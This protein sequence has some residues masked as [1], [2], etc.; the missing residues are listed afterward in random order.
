MVF[1]P[2]KP[3]SNSH[4]LENGIIENLK[5]LK[6]PLL[7]RSLNAMDES[8]HV[9]LRAWDQIGEIELR[10]FLC[11]TECLATEGLSHSK[12]FSWRCCAV[13]CRGKEMMT[14]AMSRSNTWK[15]AVIQAC[16]GL[17]KV[18]TLICPNLMYQSTIP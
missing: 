16:Y 10:D 6:L 14:I 9:A 3:K 13:R 1:F 2:P 7:C 5:Y 12:K 4:P 8:L 18:M 17:D 11:R 15:P